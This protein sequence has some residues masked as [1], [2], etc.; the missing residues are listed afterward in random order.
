MEGER[1]K[2]RKGERERRSGKAE[3]EIESESAWGPFISH[4]DHIAD[5]GIMPQVKRQRG[6]HGD[7]AAGIREMPQA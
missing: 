4:G 5:I 2:G 7:H 1:E 6:R 3:R